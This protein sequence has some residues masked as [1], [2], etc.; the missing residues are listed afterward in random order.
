MNISRF[1]AV[2]TTCALA[3]SI[4]TADASKA[5]ESSRANIKKI[6][7]E[8]ALA[9]NVP[10]SL[11]L[12][13]AKVESD[14]QAHVESSKGARGV[15]QIMPATG[16]GEWGVE[17]DE[18]WDP[19]LN[20][21]LGIDYLGQLIERYDGNWEFA[22][23][24]YNG[25]SKV[26]KPGQARVLPWTRKYVN[27]VLRWEQRYA[28]Q[29][30]IWMALVDREDS[31]YGNGTRKRKLA[32][33]QESDTDTNV[34]ADERSA[35]MAVEVAKWHGEDEDQR[36]AQT[37]RPRVKW[38]NTPKSKRQSARQSR[39][40]LRKERRQNRKNRRNVRS[41]GDFDNIEKR[42]KAIRGSL[43]DFS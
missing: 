41:N 43:D 28:A 24:F 12:A 5:P 30:K 23:S 26:G 29:R 7:V 32:M 31:V 36:W 33:L 11:A 10:P 17:P 27:N 20:V 42:L 18:L 21:R 13:V 39:Q 9:T 14:F 1:T 40:E 34:S 35:N 22:L 6:V 4:S 15:M 37:I 3:L 25:G 19:R 38:T 8:E 2:I 16:T